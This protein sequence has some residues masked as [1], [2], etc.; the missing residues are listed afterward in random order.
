MEGSE[1]L[2]RIGEIRGS[3]IESQINERPTEDLCLP[4][5]QESEQALQ[6]LYEPYT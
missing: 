4:G 6:A 3:T 1:C 2:R 5:E